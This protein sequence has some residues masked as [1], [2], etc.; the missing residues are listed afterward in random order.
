MKLFKSIDDKL[1][2]LGF[3]KVVEEG[4]TEDDLGTCYRRVVPINGG[5]IYVHRLDILHKASGKHLI[6]SYEEGTNSDGF[7][8]TVGLT[9]EITKLAMKKYRQLKRKYKWN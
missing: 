4:E 1:K 2:D 7:N 5:D 3:E 6:Q 9:Y 8:N